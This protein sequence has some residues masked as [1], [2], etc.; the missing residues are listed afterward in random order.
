V[1]SFVVT[2]REY[3]RAVIGWLDALPEDS[4]AYLFGAAKDSTRSSLHKTTRF[5]QSEREWL[6]TIAGILDRLGFRSWIYREGRSRNFWVLETSAPFLR[7][8]LDFS[9]ASESM[10]F[11][12]ARGY[13][14]A[15]GGM[16]RVASA[17]LYFQF[18]Q[19]DRVDLNLLRD[20]LVSV[21]M[22]CGALHN[23]S[24]QADPNYWRFFI[25]ARSHIDFM[26]R[27]GS[28]HPVK[29]SLMAKRL[30]LESETG[31]LAL[32]TQ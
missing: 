19:K 5:G 26:K 27:V 24:R 6:E 23:P 20:L 21:G 22:G 29:A 12:Y 14:D 1:P 2:Q 10:T 8:P 25:S 16:P 30:T 9:N 28:W 13:F 18:V 4:R 11:S 7:E 3:S 17:R 32:E 31:R 15:D